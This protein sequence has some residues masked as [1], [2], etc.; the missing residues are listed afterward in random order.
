MTR[1]A[2]GLSAFVMFCA[3]SATAQWSITG[4]GWWFSFALD[5]LLYMSIGVIFTL[6]LIALEGKWPWS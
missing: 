5:G 6:F 1:W 4:A 3:L 2:A